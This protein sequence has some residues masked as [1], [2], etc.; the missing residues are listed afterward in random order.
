MNLLVPRMKKAL[1]A[2][3]FASSA[4][5]QTIT[6]QTVDTGSGGRVGQ[7]TALAV[8]AGNPAMIYRDFVKS[9][10]VFTR[11]T[12]AD[13]SGMWVKT[14]IASDVG[15]MGTADSHALRIVAG[16]PAAVF[17]TGAGVMFARSSTAD[18]SGAWTVTV[19]SDGSNSAYSSASLEIVAGHPAVA[20]YKGDL[21]FA[22]CSTADGSGAWTELTVDAQGAAETVSLAIV[23][24]KPAIAYRKQTSFVD[25]EAYSYYI[26]DLRYARCATVDGLGAWTTSN[27][28]SDTGSG[29]YASLTEVDGRPAISYYDAANYDLRYASNSAADGSG[30]WA[31]TAVDATN[32]TG[33]YTSLLVV[34]GKPAIAYRYE[35]SADLRYAC[36]AAADGTGA[37]TVTNVATAGTTGA[38]ASLAIVNG[39]PA[40]GYYYA[41]GFDLMWA[42]NALADGSGVWTLATVD[43]AANTGRVGKVPMLAVVAGKPMAVYQDDWNERLK[44]A[45]AS[46]SDGLASWSSQTPSFASSSYSG[47]LAEVDGRPGIAYVDGTT[48]DVKFSLNANADGSGAWTTSTVLAGT[49]QATSLATVGSY[50]TILFR[51][52]AAPYSVQVARNAATN[53]TGAWTTVSTGASST[54]ISTLAEVSGSAAFAF[55]DQTT[56]DLKF[57]RNTAADLSGTW[58]TSVIQTGTPPT[59]FSSFPKNYQPKLVIADGKPGVFF[60]MNDGSGNMMHFAINNAADGSGAWTIS[61]AGP[62]EN[63]IYNVGISAGK[64]AYCQ[65]LATYLDRGDLVLVRNTAADGNGAWLQYTVES[66]RAGEDGALTM[67]GTQ[68]GLAFYDSQN[69]NLEY[70]YF[71]LGTAS[72]TV[73]QPTTQVLI[74]N[75]ASVDF[76]AVTITTP[77]PAKTFT[78]RNNGTATLTVTGITKDGANA[79]DFALSSSAGFTL[80]PGATQSVSVTFTPSVAGLRTAALHVL[81]DDAS[82][83]SFN[84]TLTGEGMSFSGI[85][86]WRQTWFG[87]LANTGSAADD[88]DSD[89]DGTTNYLE[90]AYGLNPTLADAIP[91]TQFTLNGSNIEFTYTRGTQSANEIYFAVPWTET[92]DGTDWY[93]ADTTEQILSDNGTQQVIKAT[94]PMGTNGRRFV[95]LEVW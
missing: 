80:A 2:L 57:S 10:L 29:Y 71:D 94:I 66:G 53:A 61:T 22:R 90:Y 7:N 82:I 47:S 33:T 92:L 43:N 87:T 18:G 62:V 31:L 11:N 50:P 59:D 77:A 23:N 1:L 3:L 74:N 93:Y 79:A 9:Q 35:T 27:V 52:Y 76:S 73:E 34:D 70:A 89:T 5:S 25:G 56:G 38:F 21:T 37:W 39:V 95:R 40:I 41:S 15:T 86:T 45:A 88:A 75:T 19:L 42:K 58:V 14:K 64:P 49:F 17:S 91:G 84:V 69:K 51:D 63:N 67:V 13:G 85:E 28:E 78:V 12:A 83:P 46:T 26:G 8:V 4:F 30:T 81:S 65:R 60:V 55:I 36:N 68:T 6:N 48:V 32:L 20:F 72:I 24:G 16:N 44:F 54:Q